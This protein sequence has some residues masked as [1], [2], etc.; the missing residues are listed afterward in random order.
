MLSKICGPSG[1]PCSSGRDKLVASL[2]YGVTNIRFRYRPGGRDGDG[3][4]A[5]GCERYLNIANAIETSQCAGDAG[6]AVPAGLS[7]HLICGAHRGFCGCALRCNRR[8]RL[9]NAFGVSGASSKPERGYIP[10]GKF[11]V[12]CAAMAISSRS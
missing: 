4:N 1:A 11:A 7:G 2:G 3:G 8:D 9:F 10:Q 5:A 6:R 12:L